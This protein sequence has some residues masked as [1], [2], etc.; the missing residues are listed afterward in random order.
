MDDLIKKDDHVIMGLSFG[1]HDSAAAILVNGKVLVAIQEERLS[2]IKHDNSFP[3]NAIRF[4]LQRLKIN[5]DRLNKIIYYENP[6]KKF[7]RIVKSLFKLNNLGNFFNLVSDWYTKEKFDPMSKIS[8]F[9]N[10]PKSEIE[11]FDHHISHAAAAFF[12]S[13]YEE[14]IIITIDGVGEYETSTISIGK[15]N[16]IIK[17]QTSIFPNSLGLFYST[18]T[19]F[20]GFEVNEGEYKVMGMAGFGKPKYV[21]EIKN[22]IKLQNGKILLNKKFFNFSLNDEY[23]FS[24]NFTNIFGRERNPRDEFSFEGKE[25]IKRNQKFADIAASVQV[26]TEEIIFE[27]FKF[28]INKFS[29]NNV[30]FSGG[31]ALNGL[32]NRKI[33]KLLTDK[34]YVYPSPGDAGSAVGCAQYYYFSKMN[35]KRFSTENIFYGNSFEIKELESIKNNY[36]K[37]NFR[38]FKTRELLNKFVASELNKGKIIGWFQGKEEW[39]PRAL[40]SR[41]I[42]ANPTKKEMRDKVNKIIKYREIFRPFAPSVLTEK[43]HD[44]FDVQKNIDELSPE[45]YMLTVNDVKNRAIKEAPA[46]V[47][48]DKTARVHAVS[49]FNNPTFYQLIK[50]FYKLTNVPILLN[51]SFNLKGEPIV[52]SVTDAFRTFELSNIDLLVI[53]NYCFKRTEIYK[54]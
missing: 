38:F 44:Y 16:K 4:C 52:S 6:F 41:S 43:V 31:V 24:K 49:K 37:N 10:Y 28:C 3:E 30:V 54:N 51:T 5:S 25:N 13:K 14:S 53:E 42:L 17:K 9:M 12:S 36:P 32:A 8:T 20:L 22:L 19:S 15:K 11:F 1:Y 35:K 45:N 48:I 29:I 40:G 46:I 21:K 18:F 33:Q 34:L 2:R 23:P 27:M 26:V 47:H 7:D 50:D 39:G